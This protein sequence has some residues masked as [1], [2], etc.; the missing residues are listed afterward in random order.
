[1][2]L[3]S[4]GNGRVPVV[5]L[6][7]V[8]VNYGKLCALAIGRLAIYPNERIFV[9]G[10]SGSGKTTFAKV[11][12]NRVEPAQGRVRVLGQDFTH[13]DPATRRAIQ[14]RLAMIDQEFHLVPR[15]SVI[16]NVLNG[17]LGRVSTW[18]SLAGW[19]PASE[20]R[21]AESILKEVDLEGL[22]Y[23]RVETLSG[24]QRQ[25]TAIARALMQDADVILADEPVSN[26]DPEL[27][28]D[29]LELLVRCTERREVT[30]VVNLHQPRLARRFATRVLGLHKGR[31]VFD[32]PPDDLTEGGEEFIYLGEEEGAKPGHDK[33]ATALA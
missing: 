27:A 5:E 18:K 1:M 21:Q 25:R 33:P 24:G 14:R 11:I 9:L 2:G 31:V 10:R 13:P 29:A 8:R 23:R 20:W 22:G 16:G 3:S 6:E 30:L 26:L 17:A 28:E 32:G 7:D 19:F 15:M 12:K 4:S